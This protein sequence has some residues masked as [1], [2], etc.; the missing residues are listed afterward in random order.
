M[1]ITTELFLGDCK[2]ELKKIPDNSVDLS[3]VKNIMSYF[4][5]EDTMALSR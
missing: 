1:K 5:R 4:E 2:K 3:N